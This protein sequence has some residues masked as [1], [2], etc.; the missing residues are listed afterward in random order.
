MNK[1][2]NKNL[3]YLGID[4]QFKLVHHLIE[5]KKYFGDMVGILDNNMFTDPN[6]RKFMGSAINYFDVYG[7]SPSY[8]TVAID[9]KIGAKDEIESA[10][11]DELVET[12]KHSSGEGVDMV[13]NTAHRFFKQQNY[14]KV[15]NKVSELLRV[16]DIDRI[17]EL[18]DLWQKAMMLGNRDDMGVKLRD[19]LV[20]VLSEDYRQ[21]IPT[22]VEGID[23]ILEGGLGKGELGVIIGSSGFGK[24]SMTTAFAN[25]SASLGFK[26][27]QIIFEDKPKQIQRKHIS[28]IT[29]IEA[30][31][32]SKPENLEN[33]RNH[34]EE[35]NKLDDTLIIKKFPTGEI[36]PLQIKNYLK[37]LINLGFTPENVLVDYFECLTPSRNFRDQWEG[38]GNTMREL[39]SIASDLDVAL[40]VP[41]QGNKDSLSAEIVTM[42]NAGGSFKKMQIAHIVISIGRAIEDIANNI[43][44]IAIL[45][46]RS[47]KSG[48]VMNGVYFNN[49]TCRIDTTNSVHYESLKE[50][51][52]DAEMKKEKIKKEIIERMA[53]ISGKNKKDEVF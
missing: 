9:L 33:V 42:E 31:N 28:R 39:E 17:D 25:H 20:D 44:T 32:L 48:K 19:N 38:E 40:W 5:D 43:A 2:E 37:K 21:T 52:D 8:E 35:F 34:M 24:T 36:S 51:K 26:T 29:N 45:K 11:I 50:S 47:G 23:D 10:E 4:F 27:V 14:T 18:E 46:N 41:T 53:E 15:I 12:I 7:I 1:I 6:L 13:K 49:G 3:G 30:R 16:G 22:G